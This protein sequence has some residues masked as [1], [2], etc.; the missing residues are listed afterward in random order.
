MG[1]VK[2]LA[3]LTDLRV[4]NDLL[5]AQKSAAKETPCRTL[6]SGLLKADTE[7]QVIALLSQEGYWDDR[8]AWRYFGDL[9]N[10]WS[11]IVFSGP[12]RALHYCAALP[13]YRRGRESH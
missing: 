4:L 7:E 8:D 13:V 1:L 2:A 12:E 9:E 11:T 5:L 3:P 6:S 10:N